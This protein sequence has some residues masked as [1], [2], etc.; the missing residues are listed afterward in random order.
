[1]KPKNNVLK[2]IVLL[3]FV[4]IVTILA[5]KLFSM[6]ENDE[7]NIFSNKNVFGILIYILTYKL[8]FNG[9]V[10][11]ISI[12]A[13][14]TMLFFVIFDT[15]KRRV[16]EEFGSAK[17]TSFREL[18]EFKDKKESNNFIISQNIRISKDA[19][20]TDRNNNISVVGG[21]GSRKTTGIVIPNILNTENNIVVTDPKGDTYEKSRYY[22]EY[23]GYNCRAL[24]ILELIKSCKY[25]PL[26]YIF[27][28]EEV[29]KTSDMIVYSNVDKTSEKDPFWN[30]E[31]FKLISAIIEYLMFFN[32]NKSIKNMPYVANLI[33]VLS[34]KAKD[35]QIYKDM[36]KFEKSDDKRKRQLANK[37]LSIFTLPNTTLGTVLENTSSKLTIFTNEVVAEM[38]SGEDETDIIGLGYKEKQA[39]F[40]IIPDS[41]DKTFNLIIDMFYFQLFD[42]LYKY[43]Y[44]HSDSVLKYPLEIYLDEIANIKLPDNFVSILSTVRSR[45]I[46]LIML[47][48]ALS[49]IDE[50]FDK[51]ADTIKANCDTI[52]YLGSNEE[53]AHKYVSETIGKDT[54]Y[55]KNS[56]ISRGRNGSFSQT[57]DALGR[58]ILQANEVRTLSRDNCVVFYNGKNPVLDKKYVMF[59]RGKIVNEKYK[60]ALM[61]RDLKTSDVSN[62][63]RE[64]YESINENNDKRSNNLMKRLKNKYEMIYLEINKVFKKREYEL[65]LQKIEELIEM[66]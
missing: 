64:L 36:E 56:S 25:N 29:L 3:I 52:I 49:Q 55:K 7:I 1:M 65:L 6:L 47:F 62:I 38:M 13:I 30:L 21:S 9:M 37:F 14:V 12:G 32:E 22:L 28:M 24:N 60:K 11:G 35:T 4:I 5:M 63:L 51:S 2:Y 58:E 46:S 34:Y 45:G 43:S 40:L 33:N 53:K 18:L 54:I 8:T 59:K 15:R 20:M 26:K 50:K 48:Q 10:A 57:D 27:N 31:S 41:G 42:T 16:G 19:T 23:K 39:L 66:S 61:Y 44:K 17:L